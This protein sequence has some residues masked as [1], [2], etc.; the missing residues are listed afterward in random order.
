LLDGFCSRVSLAVVA[1]WATDDLVIGFNGVW[2]RE[3]LLTGAKFCGT[4]I[5][6]FFAV[7]ST[8]LETTFS[9]RLLSN[10]AASLQRTDG[11]LAKRLFTKAWSGSGKPPGISGVSCECI[12]FHPNASSDP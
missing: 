5:D 9:A 11:F 8:L 2:P 4:S 6:A 7:S 10:A 1:G 3:S 12:F